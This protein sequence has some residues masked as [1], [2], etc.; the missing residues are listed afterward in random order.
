MFNWVSGERLAVS[1]THG[2]VDAERA[3]SLTIILNVGLGRRVG[4][5]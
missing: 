3:I 4:R 2:V 1:A 5:E